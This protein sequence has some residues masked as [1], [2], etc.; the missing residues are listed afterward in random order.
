MIAPVM[1]V[2]IAL[3]LTATLSVVSLSQTQ[4]TQ[5]IKDGRRLHALNLA[6]AGVDHVLW[7][8]QH[9]PNWRTV[10]DEQNISLGGGQ[11]HLTQLTQSNGNITSMRVQ[12]WVPSVNAP[13][14][15][16]SELLVE[17]A[18]VP[19]GPWAY[20]VVGNDWVRMN[21]GN[22]DSYNSTNDRPAAVRLGNG[23]I[24]TNSTSDQTILIGAN[25]IVLGNA[26]Y[27][28]GGSAAAVYG[29]YHT[30]PSHGIHQNPVD[31]TFKAIPPIPDGA[32]YLCGWCGG[33]LY[34]TTGS[35]I[36]QP[37]AAGTY[38][39]GHFALAGN[40][41][42]QV[43][44]VGKTTFYCT[45][46]MD[47]GG[48]GVLNNAHDPT[49]LLIFGTAGCTSINLHGNG[50]F[51]GAIYAPQADIVQNGGGST[52][53]VYGSI[54]GKTVTFT[55]NTANTGIVFDEAISGGGGVA[56][57]RVVGWTLIR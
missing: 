26:Y 25:G 28:V 11:Y 51:H 33:D 36:A 50:D 53:K 39:M 17:M 40:D 22:T 6:E 29:P 13:D 45:E 35:V 7:R 49:H 5:T 37:L 18:G 24:A 54:A 19:G 14:G 48:N 44:G 55:G 31:T 3:L 23:D 1:T 12:G 30:P 34:T 56:R 52:G 20:A 15:T 8:L 47:L 21:N 38:V 9:D 16:S 57:Y 41:E 43:A 27:P 42:V 32:T 10:A 4:R 46:G 2:M